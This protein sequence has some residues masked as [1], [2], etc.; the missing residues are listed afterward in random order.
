MGAASDTNG[1]YMILNLSP[2]EYTVTISMIGY[3][4]V[5]YENVKFPL[6]KL[7]A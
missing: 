2:N 3:K 1:D 5:T 6:I 4:T 7:L